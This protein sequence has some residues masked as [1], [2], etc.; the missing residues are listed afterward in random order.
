EFFG[1]YNMMGKFATVLG[2]LLV[3]LVAL[4]T[5]SSRASIA[6]LAILFLAGGLV[7]LL[8]REPDRNG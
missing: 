2:P 1:F 4:T 5:G 6:S 8:V 7:L 3:A